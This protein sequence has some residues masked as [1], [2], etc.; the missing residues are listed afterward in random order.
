MLYNPLTLALEQIFANHLPQIKLTQPASLFF[1]GGFPNFLVG[2]KCIECNQEFNSNI[3]SPTTCTEN[4][5]IAR[6]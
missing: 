6:D 5:K 2:V 1:G 3:G 4:R